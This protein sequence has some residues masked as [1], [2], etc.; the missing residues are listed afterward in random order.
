MITAVIMQL[1]LWS[2]SP[3]IFHDK[4]SLQWMNKLETSFHKHILSNL[5]PLGHTVFEHTVHQLAFKRR[6][7]MATPTQF[8]PLWQNTGFL[9]FEKLQWM[10]KWPLYRSPH[11]TYKNYT[12]TEFTVTTC[13]ATLARVFPYIYA[14]SFIYCNRLTKKLLAK[15]GLTSI[16]LLCPLKIPQS[17][18]RQGND[19][20][21]KQEFASGLHVCRHENVCVQ[22]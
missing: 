2:S 3:A 11:K 4:L 14:A 13:R 12:Y 5:S 6:A 20:T 17:R 7:V 15:P 8:T 18:S 19:Q 22:R 9:N 16:N 21:I 10:M 1:E